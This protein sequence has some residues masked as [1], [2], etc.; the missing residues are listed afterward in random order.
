MAAEQGKAEEEIVYSLLEKAGFR[1]LEKQVPVPGE[2]INCK[3]GT[4]DMV[5]SRDSSS[6]LPPTKYVGE[7]KRLGLRRYIDFA[8]RGTKKAHAQYY[9]QS[10]LYMAGLEIPR[11][12]IVA[13][14]ADY[15]AVRHYWGCQRFDINKIVPPVWA[16]MVTADPLWQQACIA[17]AKEI[18]GHI[19]A[20]KEA[21]EVP[22]DFNPWED[23]FPCGY[24]GWQAACQEAG[25]PI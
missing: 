2:K 8:V 9:T 19:E 10:Q 16:E 23:R 7:I 5:L 17:R 12:I 21:R 14:S 15:S 18:D 20:A 11:A 1:V 3:Q 13:V 4:A 25:F 6:G 24:C 22:R